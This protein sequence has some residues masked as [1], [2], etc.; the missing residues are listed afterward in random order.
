MHLLICSFHSLLVLIMAILA[1]IRLLFLYIGDIYIYFG[2]C[3]D[4]MNAFYAQL[5]LVTTIFSSEIST[6][7]WSLDRYFSDVSVI[8]LFYENSFE[9][10][11][12]QC[13]LFCFRLVIFVHSYGLQLPDIRG[14]A[15]PRV[16]GSY[17]PPFSFTTQQ[18]MHLLSPVFVKIPYKTSAMFRFLLL[19][20]VFVV[21]TREV[22]SYETYDGGVVFDGLY[23][24]VKQLSI[25]W[26][27]F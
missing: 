3:Q 24:H 6:P 26:C 8:I 1:L 18:P 21:V 16:S 11:H 19:A 14:D 23:I 20:I 27:I 13:R 5:I 22:K 17:I 9:T 15:S 4:K 25:L 10:S 7:I 12:A 2:L